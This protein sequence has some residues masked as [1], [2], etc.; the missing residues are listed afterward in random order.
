MMKYQ[1]KGDEI[2]SSDDE[3]TF[4]HQKKYWAGNLGSTYTYIRNFPAECKPMKQFKNFSPNYYDD[5]ELKKKQHEDLIDHLLSSDEEFFP[6]NK[7]QVKS[8]VK[9]LRARSHRFDTYETT[10]GP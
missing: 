7:P 5:P 6:Q 3:R 2:G 4:S 1:Q 8:K 10:F 9:P